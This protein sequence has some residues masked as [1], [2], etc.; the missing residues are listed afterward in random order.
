MT[1]ENRHLST[2]NA[3]RVIWKES[4]LPALLDHTM[5]DGRHNCETRLD[6]AAV[7]KRIIQIIIG[8]AGDVDSVYTA[9]TTKQLVDAIDSIY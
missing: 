2:A 1:Y 3:L 4:T 7:N 9:K 8:H 5:H 6:N